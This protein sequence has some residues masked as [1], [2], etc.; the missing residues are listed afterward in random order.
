MTKPQGDKQKKVEEYQVCCSKCKAVGA[1][2]QVWG[3]CSVC[4]S[5]TT[6]SR[7]CVCNEV[8]KRVEIITEIDTEHGHVGSSSQDEI[9]IC[10]NEECS[11]YSLV[12]YFT[13]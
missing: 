13:L 2:I 6:E 1:E 5:Y 4:A 11:Q 10:Q 12:K 8:M 9:Y 3:K 7:L